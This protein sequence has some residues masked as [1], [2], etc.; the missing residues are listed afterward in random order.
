MDNHIISVN[1]EAGIHDKIMGRMR[2]E[3][4]IG[5]VCEKAP[6]RKEDCWLVSNGYSISTSRYERNEANFQWID[7]VLLDVDNKCSNPNLLNE[8]RD[9]YSEYEYWLWETASSSEACPKFR[10]IFPLDKHIEWINEPAKITKLAI[11]EHFKK[12]TDDKASWYFSPTSG[13]LNT[14]T[15]HLGKEYPASKILS[16]ME[17]MKQRVETISLNSHIRQAL[18]S[19]REDVAKRNPNGWRYLPIV[20]KCLKGLH[21][22]ERDSSLHAACYAMDKNGYRSH[23]REF[24]DEVYCDRSVK[25]KF[26]RKYK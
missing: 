6:Q 21:E 10:V 15:H 1:I 2:L 16:E 11:K 26:Y 18:Q 20:Q 3:D 4:A 13:K 22:G 17:T 14:V 8:F 9:E 12:Y 5:E 19:C 23:I 25:E 24:L 7:T